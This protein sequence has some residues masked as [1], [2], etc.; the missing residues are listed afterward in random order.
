MATE[1]RANPAT[2]HN[3]AFINGVILLFV[4][5]IV[6]AV[7]GSALNLRGWPLNEVRRLG[8]VSLFSA[9]PRSCSP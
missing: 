8:W 9:A 6:R 7:G 5:A 2:A 3:R 1:F 4:F